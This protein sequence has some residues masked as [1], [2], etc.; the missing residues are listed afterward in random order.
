MA[1][2]SLYA[3][4][5]T[6]YS[7]RKT[8]AKTLAKRAAKKSVR[9][10]VYD[11]DD[12]EDDFT[13]VPQHVY[14]TLQYVITAQGLLTFVEMAAAVAIVVL[15]VLMTR[16]L[17]D[18]EWYAHMT[19]LVAFAYAL[20]GLL[21]IISALTSPSTQMHLPRT[22]FYAL[23]QCCGGIGYGFAGVLLYMFGGDISLPHAMHAGLTGLGVSLVHFVHTILNVLLLMSLEPD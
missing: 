7:S 6:L 8:T 2:R 12:E 1:R 3:K 16:K 14:F 5:K 15:Y 9:Q 11:E 21:V 10:P 13:D 18:T 22:T 4:R 17:T 20:N 19:F 23:Y